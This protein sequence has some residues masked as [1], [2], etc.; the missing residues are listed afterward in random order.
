MAGWDV[1][2]V[3][4]GAAVVGLVSD[5][6]MYGSEDVGRGG[7]DSRLIEGRIEVETERTPWATRRLVLLLLRV[8]SEVTGMVTSLDSSMMTL[9][10]SVLFRFLSERGKVAPL[11]KEEGFGKVVELV[12]EVDPW[13][14]RKEDICGSGKKWEEGDG[15]GDGRDLGE[16]MVISSDF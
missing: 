9:S 8:S 7:G 15:S 13:L 1:A 4:L 6:I 14:T 12:S 11:V 3:V 10:R 2:V 16:V 5:W